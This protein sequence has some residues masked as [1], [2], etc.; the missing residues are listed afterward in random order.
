MSRHNLKNLPADF[1]LEPLAIP[2]CKGCWGYILNTQAGQDKEHCKECR[3]TLRDLN[4]LS[5]EDIYRADIKKED[6]QVREQPGQD[7]DLNLEMVRCRLMMRFNK[8]QYRVHLR[9]HAEL[10]FKKLT[11]RQNRDMIGDKN[12]K[13]MAEIQVLKKESINSVQKHASK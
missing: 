6:E 11:S 5:S 2:R 4:I 9:K 7:L 12:E 3:K 1:F 10:K 8:R 13:V